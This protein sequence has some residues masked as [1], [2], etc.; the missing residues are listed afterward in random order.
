MEQPVLT[1]CNYEDVIGQ[2]EDA[3]EQGHTYH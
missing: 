1:V 3:C 2:L